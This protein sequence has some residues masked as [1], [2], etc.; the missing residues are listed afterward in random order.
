[1]NRKPISGIALDVWAYVLGYFQ[2]NQYMPTHGEIAQRF[3]KSHE[4]A[5][6][7]LL[8]LQRQKKLRV[9]PNKHRGIILNLKK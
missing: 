4:W 5:R 8:E 3:G 1:M 9:V 7:C 2:D 6:L